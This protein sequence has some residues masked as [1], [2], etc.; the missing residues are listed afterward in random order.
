MRKHTPGPWGVIQTGERGGFLIP[1]SAARETAA[2]DDD[3][4]GIA[5][6]EVAQADARLIA[7]SPDMFNALTVLADVAESR[8]IPVDAAR[9]ALRKATGEPA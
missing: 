8:G 3:D 2:L 6:A 7:A 5:A 4:H 1:Q 9:A